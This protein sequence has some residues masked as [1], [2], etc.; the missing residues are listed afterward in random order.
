MFAS[1]AGLAFALPSATARLFEWARPRLA[2][3]AV[4]HG[5]QGGLALGQGVMGERMGLEYL[6]ACQ[7]RPGIVSKLADQGATGG[8]VVQASAQLRQHR[9]C[10]GTA[11]W[12]KA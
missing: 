5:G 6:L 10:L 12:Q 4:W 3:P 7:K 9:A 11:R 1:R 8:Q 2:D